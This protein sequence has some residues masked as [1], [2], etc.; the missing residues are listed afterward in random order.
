MNLDDYGTFA[1]LDP[2]DMLSQINRLPEQLEAAFELGLG[3]EFPD[4]AG[5]RQILV[6]GMGG[7]A[8]GAD[9]AAAYAAPECRAPM[10]V[11]RDY[12]APAWA[13][14]PETLA[15]L[16]SHS[17][18]TEETLSA[19]EAARQ[20]NCR[21]LAITTGG[22]LAQIASET[23][24]PVWRFEHAGQPRAAV[25]Y[26][27]GLLLA[28]L[29]CAGLLPDPAKE[30]AGAVKAMRKQQANLRAETPAAQNPAKRI[31]GQLV[32]RW[33]TVIGSGI[34]APVAR[35]W[36][37]QISEIA[38]AWA[39]FEALPEA[40]HNTLA[41]IL[42]PEELFAHSITLFLRAASNHPRNRLRSDLTRRA[43]MLEGLNGDFV[44]AQGETPLAQL[45]T[46]LHFGDYVSYYLAM[47]YGVDPT[48]VTAIESFK[49]EL[50]TAG[51][52]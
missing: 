35:R 38:K 34:L 22:K 14:G 52:G 7:S 32:G 24:V 27:F 9:L 1:E 15:I 33:V 46:C 10:V 5:I 13:R 30:L 11:H 40:N 29:A 36:K 25:G 47:A 44:D 31:A 50:R 28:A 17:G 18:S 48:P 12:G 20:N 16:C 41:G 51:S 23:G 37:G 4:W 49:Q 21:C 3:L 39:Q 19:F 43:F 26:S 6:A 42:N 2:Q 45:W 8:I